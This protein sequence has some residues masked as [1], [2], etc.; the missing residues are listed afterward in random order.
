MVLKID[1]KIL[2]CFLVFSSLESW[3]GFSEDS[4]FWFYMVFVGFGGVVRFFWFLRWF[5]V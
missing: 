1:V 4:L 2:N 5:S 3:K